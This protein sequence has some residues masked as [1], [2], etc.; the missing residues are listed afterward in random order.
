[1]S[2]LSVKYSQSESFSRILQMYQSRLP[3]LFRIFVNQCPVNG[4]ML[5]LNFGRHPRAHARMTAG[6]VNDLFYFVI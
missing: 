6:F 4:F 2:P 5:C 3:G 1:M